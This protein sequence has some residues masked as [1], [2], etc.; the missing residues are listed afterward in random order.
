MAR[1]LSPK[2]SLDLIA[3]EA[4]ALID[5]GQPFGVNAL[6]RRLGVTPSSLY[7]HVSGRDEIVE[8]VRARM[9]PDVGMHPDPT[10]P[11]DEAL[12]ATLWAQRRMYASHPHAILLLVELTITSP[13]VVA[14]YA[15]LADLLTDA[16]FPESD[17]LPIIEMLDALAIGFG[18]DQASPSAI[19]QTSDTSSRFGRLLATAEHGDGR[20]DHA[21][22]LALSLLIDALRRRL[23]GI[24]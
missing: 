6:A 11:W 9:I 12:Q 3:E 18:I 8:L 23:E 14:F 10:L 21:F 16:G 4:L 20:S 24:H 1:P 22:E 7:S 19:W 15:R 17:V 5:S 2:L 13:D